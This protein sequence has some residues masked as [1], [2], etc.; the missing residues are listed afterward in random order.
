MNASPFLIL[1]RSESVDRPEMD[2]V[3]VLAQA[4]VVPPP[5]LAQATQVMLLPSSVSGIDSEGVEPSAKTLP[6]T[7]STK[8][9]P[10]LSADDHCG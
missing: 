2:G 4:Y 5:L 10:T 8:T 6:L 1:S 9:K 3:S 7:S